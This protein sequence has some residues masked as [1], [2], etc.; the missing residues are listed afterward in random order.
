MKLLVDTPLEASKV[1]YGVGSGSRPAI[2]NFSFK[3][4]KFYK[5]RGGGGSFFSRGD[6]SWNCGGKGNPPP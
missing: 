6:F 5:I 1:T 4:K 3:E 2:F